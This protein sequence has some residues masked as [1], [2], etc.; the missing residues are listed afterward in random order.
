MWLFAGVMVRETHFRNRTI[1][2]C[3]A[4]ESMLNHIRT[5]NLKK[6]RLK[7]A[8]LDRIYSSGVVYWILWAGSSFYQIYGKYFRFRYIWFKLKNSWN[9]CSVN[10][11]YFSIF[12][13]YNLR[14]ALSLH[15]HYHF[16]GKPI[17][18]SVRHIWLNLQRLQIHPLLN[19][20]DLH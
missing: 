9:T 15:R 13:V 10:L 5:N 2:P 12:F 1:W 16:F 18:H 7:R 6:P 19:I 20:L 3:F 14:R 8:S 4:Y 17:Q 11:I